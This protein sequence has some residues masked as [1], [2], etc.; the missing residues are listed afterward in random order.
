MSYIR[1]DMADIRVT[2]DGV[3]YGDSWATAEGGNL[4]ADNSKTRPGGM[5]DEVDVGG[6][7]SRDDLTLGIQFSDVV[8][9]WHKKFE[10]RV[11]TGRIKAAVTFLGPDKAPVGPSQTRVG[12]LKAANLPDFDSNGSDQAMYTIVVSCDQAAA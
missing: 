9:G 1:E 3:S 8:A 12:T 7:A 11:G 4:E 10:S 6:P 5:G 2:V